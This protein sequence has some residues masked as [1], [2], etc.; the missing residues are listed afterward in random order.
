M[1][2]KPVFF[3]K[4]T[5][6]RQS[7]TLVAMGTVQA[8]CLPAF[9]AAIEADPDNAAAQRNLARRAFGLQVGGQDRSCDVGEPGIVEAF[10]E[11][12][13]LGE[14]EVFIQFDSDH[15]GR[16][17]QHLTGLQ[18]EQLRQRSGCVERD[19]VS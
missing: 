7:S 8:T 9:S 10:H 2:F 13:E 5:I 19:F 16:G 12:G 18:F 15:A 1:Y 11:F 6:V 17:R 4:A 3:C 14:D